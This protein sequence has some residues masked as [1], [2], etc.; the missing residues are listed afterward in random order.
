[1]SN[2]EHIAVIAGVGQVNDRPADPGQ[3][4][5]SLEL[6]RAALVAADAD[7]GTG[8]L[9]A[10]DS[11][12]VVQ[13]ISCPH[14]G[15]I[16]AAL[17]KAFGATPAL[18]YQSA[19]PNGDSPIL[20]L[21]EAA[22]RI[23]AGEIRIAAVVGG[24]AL[25]T[26][27]QRAAAAARTS[28]GDQNPLRKVT[29]AKKPGYRKSY[30]LSA[31]V[32]VYP[33]YENAGRAAYGQSLAEAQRESGEIWSRFSAVAEAN[34]HAWI[35][36]ARTAEEIVAVTP[37]NRPI[38]F[39]YTKLMA[40][41]SSV[42]QGAGF[43]VTSLAEAR[44]RGLPEARLI[45]IG[46]GAAAHEPDDYLA[47]DRYDRSASLETVLAQTLLSNAL[48]VDDLDL[49]ELYSCFP[50]VPK[51]ARRAIGWPVDR[52]ATV[53][54]GLTFGGGPIAN[55]M[56]HA[57]ASMVDALRGGR[58]RTGL[59]FA[60]GGFATHNHAIVLGT[61]PFAGAGAPFPFDVQD[62]ADATR[63]AVPLLDKTYAGSA[64]IETY[65]VFYGRDGAPVSSVIVA[66]APG[67]AR[68][69]AR[70]DAGDSFLS[71]LTDGS[72]EP[73][74]R[75]GTIIVRNGLSYWSAA[76]QDDA[77]TDGAGDEVAVSPIPNTGA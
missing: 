3:G 13:Q 29:D 28:V 70:I 23:A 21:N 7:A 61:E 53:F 4:L 64:V 17:G 49:V 11:I 10:L 5:D 43:L 30:G 58:G 34:P 50:C 12:A 35:R 1:M 2:P 73:V 32:D 63:G 54:G 41:N 40:A 19:G 77:H 59:L 51:M 22:N 56:S 47:R 26:A 44:R 57:V 62:Q 33:L 55:Y 48:T 8:W 42:N 38:A 66:R 9:A 45:H 69:L 72:I 6:M 25:R 15:D 60:N 46:R 39:P 76:A 37:D 52:P 75:P 68:T 67:G 31:P 18:A 74:G 27:S 14:L 20:L 36:Q 24:E 71:A 16:P 65:T